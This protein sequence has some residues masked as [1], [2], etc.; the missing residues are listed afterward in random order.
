MRARGLIASGSL[1]P[2]QQ[3][4]AVTFTNKARDNLEGR[5]AKYLSLAQRTRLVCVTN[6]HGL[7]ARIIRNH[8]RTIGVWEDASYPV[9]DWVAEQCDLHGMTYKEKRRISELLGAV[10]RQPF[11]DDQVELELRRL[12]DKPALAIELERRRK[13]VLTYDDL[14]RLAQLILR[15]DLVSELYA[16][17]FGAVLVDEFQ[18]LTPQQL[19]I[20]ERI[21]KDRITFAGDLSQSIYR[22]AGAKPEEVTRKVAEEGIPS[23]ELTESWRSSP[24]V[25]AMVNSLAGLTGAKTLIPKDPALW[26][27]GGLGGIAFFNSSTTEANWVVDLC[28]RILSHAPRHRIGILVRSRQR[29]KEIDEAMASQSG[30]DSFKWDD[31]VVDPEVGRILRREISSLVS[32]KLPTGA[33]WQIDE[34]TIEMPLDLETCRDLHEAIIRCNARFRDGETLEEVLNS[35]RIGNRET[36]LEKPGVHLLTGHAGK[37]QQFDWVIVVGAEEGSIPHYLAKTEEELI[38]EAKII[39]VMVSRARHGVVITAS[40]YVNG[41]QQKSSRFI[42]FILNEEHAGT[43]LKKNELAQT[44]EIQEWLSSADWDAIAAR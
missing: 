17:R 40:K 41:R 26:P 27:H 37:G 2:Y 30:F 28:H 9:S 15:N 1:L 6:F 29:R 3:I 44:D 13:H 21:G 42:R 12:G 7:S 10:K 39:S 11:D 20:V 22:F 31:D 34:G 32:R 18:D 8:G 4:L 14:P 24:A 23:I 43:L 25:L 35:I 38:D 36:I 33:S 19:E 5:L 16:H